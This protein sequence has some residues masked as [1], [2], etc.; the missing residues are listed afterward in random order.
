M[1]GTGGSR[2]LE[3]MNSA[4]RFAAAKTHSLT[5]SLTEAK[6]QANGNAKA[7]KEQANAVAGAHTQHLA[8]EKQAAGHRA[9]A[10]K[11]WEGFQRERSL[12]PNI[13][14]TRSR[15][16][17]PRD[18][19][20]AYAG[21]VWAMDDPFWN[22][23]QPGCV[24]ECKCGWR[25]TDR[26]PT[27]NKDVKV[28]PPS[29]GLEGNPYVTGEVFTDKHPYYADAP[30]HVPSLGPLHNDDKIAYI[31]KETAGGKQYLVHYNTIGTDEYVGNISIANAL[32]ENGFKNIRLLPQIN[33]K[34]KAL[35]ERYFGKEYNQ[36]YPLSNPDAIIDTDI[37]EFKTSSRGNFML[38]AREAAQKSNIAIISLRETIT[39]SYID[40]LVNGVWVSDDMANLRELVIINNGKAMRFA[41]KSQRG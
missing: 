7:Y 20:L 14:W 6:A 8:A 40:R 32:A 12:Y 35:R 36:M 17:N 11:Q 9:R 10:A 39:D 16:A 24:Y 34:E 15:S 4:S 3:L 13:E 1:T 22:T 31:P 33:A 23:N 5:A 27:N 25:T 18:T 2:E 38:R 26:K 37:V 41:R 21:N 29:P 19:H 30:K 28:T